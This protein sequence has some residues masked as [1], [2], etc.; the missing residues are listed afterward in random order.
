MEDHSVTVSA[1]TGEGLE[2]LRLRV[3]ERLAADPV[4]EAD[5][6]LSPS[7]GKQLALLHQSGTVVSARYEADRMLVRAKVPVSIRDILKV[8]G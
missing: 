7:D 2:N 1:Q 3:A 8:S 6:V 4:V 5:F